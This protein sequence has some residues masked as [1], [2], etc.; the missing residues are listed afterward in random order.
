M[1]SSTAGNCD[2][3]ERVE[4]RPEQLEVELEDGLQDLSDKPAESERP[5]APKAPASG[6]LPWF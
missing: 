5:A 4:G 6:R 2:D 1:A 3:D